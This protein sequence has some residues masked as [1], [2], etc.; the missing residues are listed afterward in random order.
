MPIT[1]SIDAEAKTFADAHRET[2]KGVDTI[3]Y[4]PGDDEIRLLEF[5]SSVPPTGE[6]VPFRYAPSPAHGLHHPMSL[7]LLNPEERR[8]VENQEISLPAGWSLDTANPV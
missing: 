4:F 1:D 5:T 3:L 2:D 7:I 8:L 6:A